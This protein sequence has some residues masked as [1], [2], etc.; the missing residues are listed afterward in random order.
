MRDKRAN[1]T[2]VRFSDISADPN[3][4]DVEAQACRLLAQSGHSDFGS[5]CPLLG[6]KADIEI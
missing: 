5:E 2:G 1:S 3:R 4:N 6:G